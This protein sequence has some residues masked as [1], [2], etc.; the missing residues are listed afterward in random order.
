MATVELIFFPYEWSRDGNAAGQWLTLTPK[1]S[2]DIG[3]QPSREQQSVTQSSQEDELFFFFR[4]FVTA[5]FEPVSPICC[6]GD[7]LFQVNMILNW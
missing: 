5:L 1:A 3:F 4:F 7:E 2:K 6:D